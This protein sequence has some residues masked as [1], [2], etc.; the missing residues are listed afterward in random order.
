MSKIYT[1]GEGGA[2]DPCDPSHD[3]PFNNLIEVVEIE[4]S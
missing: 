2:C 1:Y 3:H 4:E